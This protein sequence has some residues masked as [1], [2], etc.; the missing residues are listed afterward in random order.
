MYGIRLSSIGRR[1][2]RRRRPVDGGAEVPS[3]VNLVPPNK[4]PAKPEPVISPVFYGLLIFLPISWYFGLTRETSTLTFVTAILGII[5]LARL[6]GYATKEIALQ[7]NPAF[8]GLINATFGNMI[9]LLIAFLAIRKGPQLYDVVKASIIGSIIGNILLLTG[10]SIFFGGLR[11]KQ[12]RFNK[13]SVG[14][15]STMLI[16]AVCGLAVPTVYSTTSAATARQTEILSDAVAIIMALIY[17]AGLL[18]A[19]FT[20]K[21]LFDAS[22]EM[23]AAKEQTTITKRQAAFLLLGCTAAVAFESELL[24]K[25]VEYASLRMGLGQTFVGVVVIA[26]ITNI[27]EKANAIHFA[28]DN[29]IDISLEIGLSS[30]IQIALF[31]VPTLV[32]V[33]SLGNLEFLLVFTNFQII[34][35]LFAVMIVNYLSADGVCNWLEG[36]QLVTVYLIL[37]I[38]FFFM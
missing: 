26:I 23:R 33:S 3:M 7:T 1:A 36:A 24:V 35:V 27:A 13:A 8:G 12:Q 19:F 16:I 4:N 28:I 2:V 22:D 20:H 11:F 6:I 21:Y 30:A 10:L 34:A 17:F 18:F 38:A 5:P 25:N 31:V 15:S 37:A 9:E 14:V 29:K 32:L